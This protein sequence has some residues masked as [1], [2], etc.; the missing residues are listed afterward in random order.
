MMRKLLIL[1]ALLP[2][3]AVFNYAIWEKETILRE[4]ETVLLRLAP[5]DPRSLMQGDYMRLRYEVAT[6]AEALLQQE[7]RDTSSS[8]LKQGHLVLKRSDDRQARFVRLHHGEALS[9]GEWLLPYH[10]PHAYRQSIVI[11]PDSYF[12]QEGQAKIY[13]AAQFGI[14][15][16]TPDGAY[17]LTGLADENGKI[18]GN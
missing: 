8:S 15:K 5:V 4:G 2:I 10:K 11:K 18:I 13:E 16:M 3:L 14:F 1:L 6:Q 7:G 9:E 12:F 17:L